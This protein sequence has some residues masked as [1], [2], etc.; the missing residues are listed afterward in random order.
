MAYELS[1]VSVL[2]Y[3][4]IFITAIFYSQF[5]GWYHLLP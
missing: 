1:D 3:G 2:Q 5:V 4:T